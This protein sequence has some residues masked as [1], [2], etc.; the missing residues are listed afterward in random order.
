MGIR[1]LVSVMERANCHAMSGENDPD[2]RI[3]AAALVP[4]NALRPDW[5]LEM[6]ARPPTR[7]AGSARRRPTV[8]RVG[9]NGFLTELV[10]Q[11]CQQNAGEGYT[12]RIGHTVEFMADVRIKPNGPALA[13]DYESGERGD[14]ITPLDRL[15][16]LS[17]DLFAATTGFWS[18]ISP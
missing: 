13:P 4:Q 3:N 18:Q 5:R 7:G 14:V 1:A 6:T 16:E 10:P 2:R 12:I 11:R 9:L 17:K 15:E 8:V